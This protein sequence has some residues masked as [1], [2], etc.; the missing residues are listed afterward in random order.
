MQKLC[1]ICKKRV[2]NK[3]GYCPNCWNDIPEKKRKEIVTINQEK[4]GRKEPETTLEK[5]N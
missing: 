4:R 5:W 3:H 2:A 1:K